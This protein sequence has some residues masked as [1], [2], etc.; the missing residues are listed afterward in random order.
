M[1]KLLV[2]VVIGTMIAVFIGFAVAQAGMMG[3]GMGGS[4][5]PMGQSPKTGEESPGE[6][7][8][9]RPVPPEVAA[10][11]MNACIGAMEGMAQMGRMMGMMGGQG[12]I[13]GG[14]GGPSKTPSEQKQ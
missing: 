14:Q 4:Q 3:S 7:P 11:M 9:Q 6:Q 8:S 12:G 5:T 2:T 13:M 10:R 1:T